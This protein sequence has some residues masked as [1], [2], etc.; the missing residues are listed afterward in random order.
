M[1]F[2]QFLTQAEEDKEED[3]YPVLML[4][5]NHKPWM[6]AFKI[7]DTE[8]FVKDYLRN[9]RSNGPGSLDLEA[10]GGGDDGGEGAGRLCDPFA[11][12]SHH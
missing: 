10:E 12:P 6:V 3:R 7:E 1:G 5:S 11:N 8:R 9:R 4:H 2:Y